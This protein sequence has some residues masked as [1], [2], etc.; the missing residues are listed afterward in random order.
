MDFPKAEL[1][2][3]CDR[4]GIAVADNL[5]KDNLAELLVE[6]D[7]N[8]ETGQVADT[9]VYSLPPDPNFSEEEKL[10]NKISGYRI[11]IRALE[12]QRTISGGQA[13]WDGAIEEME[14][15]LE[16]LEA[17]LA[18]MQTQPEEVG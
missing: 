11:A 12:S 15:R 16:Q 7:T 10:G 8:N 2:Q 5:S 1:R 13:I 18:E 3:E 4:R 17:E 6:S 9:T 14:D